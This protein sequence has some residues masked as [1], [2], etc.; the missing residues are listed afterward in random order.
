MN[1]G[2][3]L[4]AEGDGVALET[5]GYEAV[6]AEYETQFMKQPTKLRAEIRRFF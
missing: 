6:V 1:P 2:K 5:S 3:V 4:V